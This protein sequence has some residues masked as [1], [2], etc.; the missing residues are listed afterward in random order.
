MPPIGRV[1]SLA[2]AL[3][4]VAGLALGGCNG[5]EGDGR[6]ACNAST[7]CAPGEVCGADGFCAVAAGPTDGGVSTPDAG[8]GGPPYSAQAQVQSAGGAQ[9]SSAQYKLQSAAGFSASHNAGTA[10]Y[11]LRGGL[12]GSR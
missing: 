2:T 6:V 12:V 3:V 11:Q 10:K 4:L 8:P 1:N 5:D 9:G 7:P